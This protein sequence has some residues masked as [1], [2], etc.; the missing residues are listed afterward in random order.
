MLALGAFAA[1]DALEGAISIESTHSSE[2]IYNNPAV[3][4]SGRILG[5]LVQT[6]SKRE[7]LKSSKKYQCLKR[8]VLPMLVIFV[9][10]GGWL[11][12]QQQD[13]AFQVV[14]RTGES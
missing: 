9:P 12:S 8:L 3:A 1:V 6:S 4:A 5:G 10:V 2:G 11:L 13:S 14:C 7:Q